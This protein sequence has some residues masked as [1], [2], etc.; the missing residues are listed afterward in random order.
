MIKNIFSLLTLLLSVK[1]IN[2]QGADLILINGKIFT[3]DKKNLYVGAIAIK[4]NKILA[5]GTNESIEKLAGSKTKR[6][7]LH[8]KTV[9]PGINDAHDHLGWGAPVGLKYEY[10]QLNPLGPS[11]AAVLDSLSRMIKQ[12]KA[13]QWLFGLIGTRVLSDPSMRKSLDS[14]APDNP[15]LLL[16]WWGHSAVVNGK[17]LQVAKLS[18]SNSNPL[19][20]WYERTESNKIFALQEYAELP[21]LNAW[22]TSEPENLVKGLRSY[23]QWQLALGI[24]SVQDMS[25]MF[26]A[27]ATVRFFKE[28]KLSQRIRIIAWPRTTPDGRVAT[29]WNFENTHLSALTYVS[30]IKYLIDGTPL[31]QNALMTKPYTNRANWYGRFNLPIDTVRKILNEAIHSKT[32]LMMHIVGDSSLS[33]VLSLMKQMA[34]SETW[35]TKRVRIEH[36]AVAAIT[37][38]EESVVKELGILLMHTPKYCMNSPLRS[39]LKRGILVGI[40]PDG[41]TNPFVDMMIVTSRQT[42]PAEN[43]TREQAVIAYT[44]INAYAEFAEVEKGTLSTGKLADLTVLSQDIFTIPNERLPSTRSILTMVNGKVVFQD[45]ASLKAGIRN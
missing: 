40:S 45:S 4:G 27:A 5:A 24:T 17:A 14:I 3:A 28:A 19:G 21:V 41:E 13:N 1:C 16:I 8:G 42:D 44:K 12:A 31:E 35:K 33:V 39:L 2:A 29:E 26:F 25:S 36:N 11:K 7:N 6:V 23:S 32:Q 22:L 9:I 20:G 18:D 37:P 34:S 38:A 43:I 15:V 30:G 10:S